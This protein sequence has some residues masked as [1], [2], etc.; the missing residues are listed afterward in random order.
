MSRVAGPPVVVAE[1]G[2][3]DWSA[4]PLA[5]EFVLV[6]AATEKRRRD[7]AAGRACARRALAALGVPPLP[8]LAGA[9]RQPLWPAGVVGSIT[10][11]RDFCAAA[12]APAAF[13]TALGIDAELHAALEPAVA[14]LVCTPDE[15]RWIESSAPAGVHWEAVIFSAKE[16]LYKAW[17]PGQ[18]TQLDPLDVTVSIDPEQESFAGELVAPAVDDPS[19]ASAMRA[20]RGRFAV[21]GP[22][23]FT[24]AMAFPDAGGLDP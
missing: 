23:V 20:L 21:C 1:A 5:A 2:E 12:V 8:I 3:D 4:V 15:R 10:H 24:S 7:F 17:F 18:H 22:Y 19:A 6:A 13:V 14:E 9:A 16:S 11:C